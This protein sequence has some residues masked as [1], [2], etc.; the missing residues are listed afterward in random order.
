MLPYL[1]YIS[2]GFMS[3]DRQIVQLYL[4]ECVVGQF[5]MFLVRFI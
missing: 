3:C 4:V 5:V 2:V 1:C